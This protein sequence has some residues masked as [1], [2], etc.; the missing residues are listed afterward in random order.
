MLLIRNEHGEVFCPERLV[1]FNPI[2]IKV[3]S[4]GN[5]FLDISAPAIKLLCQTVGNV[6]LKG[7]C[8]R[9]DVKNQSEGKFDASG[10]IAD[11]L[12]IRNMAEGNVELFANKEIRISHYGEGYVH[13]A[14]DAVLKDVKQY[15][16][17]AI[18]HVHA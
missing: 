4:V 8:E 7:Q 2:E 12:V 6:V 9:L 17:G 3:Q 13:Y 11:E 15:G 10:M 1:L 14:G 16:A 5:T 18:L